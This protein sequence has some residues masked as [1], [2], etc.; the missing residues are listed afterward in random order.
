MQIA[1]IIMFNNKRMVAEETIN[2]ILSISFFFKRVFK[3]GFTLKK[4]H[5]NLYERS[6]WDLNR[7]KI[8]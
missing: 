6:S 7:Q 8:Y 5:E 4:Y 1:I 3:F 2:F